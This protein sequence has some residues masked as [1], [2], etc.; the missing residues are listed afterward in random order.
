MARAPYQVLVIPFRRASA[1]SVV[2]ALFR[3]NLATGGYWQWIAGGGEDDESPLDAACREAQEEA[4]IR[5]GRFLALDSRTMVPVVN[6]AGFLWGDTTLVIPEYCFGVE[7]STPDLK[8]SDE[9]IEY[10]WSCYSDAEQLLRWDSNRIAL[11]ELDHRL[12]H[13]VTRTRYHVD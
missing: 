13:H 2:Y 3:R 7:I 12:V 4:G 6:V 9:H 11:W 10:R 5:E 1:D 8:L